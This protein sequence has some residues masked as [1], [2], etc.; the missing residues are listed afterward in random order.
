MLQDLMW[1]EKYRPAKLEE[2]A[3]SPQNRTLLEG[4]LA[5]GE[6]PHL[7]LCGPSGIGK[8]TL[9]KILVAELDCKMLLLNASNERGIET[10]RVKVGNFVRAYMKGRWNIVVLDEFDATTSEAQTALRNMMET[11]ANRARFILTANFRHKIIEPIQSRCVSIELTEMEFAER[12]QVLG[13][14]LRAEG[15]EYEPATVMDF[16]ERYPDLRRMIMSAQ[17]SFMAHGAL[18]VVAPSLVTGAEVLAAC[19]AKNW[20]QCRAWAKMPGLNPHQTLKEMFWAINEDT[21]D[22]PAKVAMVVGKAV[23]ESGWSPDPVVQFLGTCAEL[24][25]G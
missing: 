12:A 16:A 14:I 2:M 9:A 10:I 24:I 4:Y 20:T 6:I 17:T 7:L 5:A 18:V 25:Y 8:T 22:T 23:H 13:R 3:L 1:V 11:N 19:M 15:I 21:T